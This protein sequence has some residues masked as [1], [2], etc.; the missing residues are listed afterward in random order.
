MPSSVEVVSTKTYTCRAGDTFD[1]LAGQA[2]G[3]ERMAWV[4]IQENPDFCDV[5]EF[6]GGEVIDLPV[7]STVETADTLPPWRR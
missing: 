7:V 4:I 2:Y 5:V 1:L 3:Q 6:E